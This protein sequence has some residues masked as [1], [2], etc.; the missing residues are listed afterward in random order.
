[1]KL[2]EDDAKTVAVVPLA[3]T[4]YPVMAPVA[5]VQPTVTAR[6]EGD[7]TQSFKPPGRAKVLYGA[8]GG[9]LIDETF[10]DRTV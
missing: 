4:L 10:T 6:S 3:V 1:M 9:D 5:G 8:L 7:I 2:F